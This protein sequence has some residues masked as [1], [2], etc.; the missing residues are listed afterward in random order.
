MT[1]TH[2]AAFHNSEISASGNFAQPNLRACR[3]LA[4]KL[5]SVLAR[6]VGMV[7]TWPNIQTI[8]LAIESEANYSKVSLPDA[9][10][11]ILAAAQEVTYHSGYVRP[12]EWDRATAYRANNVNR[13]WFED[14]R[15]RDKSVYAEFSAK[16]RERAR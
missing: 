11:V 4:I 7:S 12:S 14:A 15:W 13:F 1:G 16:L 5:A 2:R 6:R 3:A 10:N 9:A 8:R